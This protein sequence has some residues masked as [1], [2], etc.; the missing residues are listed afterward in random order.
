MGIATVFAKPGSTH[1]LK[2]ETPYSAGVSKPFLL[3]MPRV[4]DIL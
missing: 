4:I 3:K 2:I 1:P